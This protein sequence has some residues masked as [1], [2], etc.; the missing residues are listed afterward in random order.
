MTLETLIQIYRGNTKATTKTRN[1]T[2][3]VAYNGTR[4]VQF[5]VVDMT[6]TTNGHI[7]L[8]IEAI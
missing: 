4:E 2:L 7:V 3:F 1:K 5:Q 8:L 6:E